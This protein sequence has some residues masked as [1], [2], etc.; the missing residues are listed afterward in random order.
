MLTKFCY[1]AESR[2]RPLIH[3]QNFLYRIVKKHFGSPPTT[4]FTRKHYYLNQET[5]HGRHSNQSLP[6]L[7]VFVDHTTTLTGVIG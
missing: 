2:R 6:N 3:Y 1:A 5:P 4:T 7:F